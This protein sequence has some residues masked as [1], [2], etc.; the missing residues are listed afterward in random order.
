MRDPMA[1]MQMRL[2]REGILTAEQ[3]N[4]LEKSLDHEAAEAADHALQAPLPLVSGI[5]Q[6]VYSEDLDPTSSTFA[7]EQPIAPGDLSSPAGGGR[8][9]E[10]REAIRAP[11]PTSSTPACMTKCAAIPA[12]W[13]MAKM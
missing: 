4:D 11:W 10:P 7:T 6:H 2:L 9:V 13:S 3:I 12:S 8:R 1:K 5:T